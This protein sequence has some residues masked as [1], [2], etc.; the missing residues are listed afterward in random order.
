M[1]QGNIYDEVQLFF[2]VYTQWTTY[3]TFAVDRY[4]NL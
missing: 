3:P 4:S 1:G 2:A